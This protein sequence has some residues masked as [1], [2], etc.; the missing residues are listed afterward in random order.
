ML[1]N[2]NK[3]KFLII[4]SSRT[5]SKSMEIKTYNKTIEEEKKGIYVSKQVINYMHGLGLLIF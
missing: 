3:W 1:L 5:R 2:E 4:E